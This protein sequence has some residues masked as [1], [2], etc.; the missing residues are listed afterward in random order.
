MSLTKDTLY[1]R[2]FRK[3]YSSICVTDGYQV[4][5]TVG[6]ELEDLT[7]AEC[8]VQCRRRFN[9]AQAVVPTKQ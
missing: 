5:H 4:Y 1:L 8:R 6:N 7:I 2:I 9:E 3:D